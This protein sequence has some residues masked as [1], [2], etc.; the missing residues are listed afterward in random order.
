MTHPLMMKRA[1]E[2]LDHSDKSAEYSAV[3]GRVWVVR[4]MMS[5]LCRIAGTNLGTI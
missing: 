3:S 2:T 1:C 5:D 4:W